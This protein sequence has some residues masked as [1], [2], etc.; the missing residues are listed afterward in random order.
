[1]PVSVPE[2]AVSLAVAAAAREDDEYVPSLASGP[3]STTSAR[4]AP[5]DTMP[6]KP[7]AS[8]DRTLYLT[9]VPVAVFM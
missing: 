6:A 5:I 3:D 8:I 1:M 9:R 2:L 4:A 7:A